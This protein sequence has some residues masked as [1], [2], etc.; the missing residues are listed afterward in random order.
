MRM[1]PPLSPFI[2]LFAYS[3]VC[4]QGAHIDDLFNSNRQSRLDSYSKVSRHARR[5]VGDQ[6]LG[7][8]ERSNTLWQEY[9]ASPSAQFHVEELIFT[10]CHYRL[11]YAYDYTVQFDVD[12]FW[13]PGR[14]S[15]AKT[16]PD[17]L[18]QHM[19]KD[20]ASIGFKQVSSGNIVT[21]YLASIN[22]TLRWQQSTRA[23][24]CSSRTMRYGISKLWMAYTSWLM[25]RISQ[26]IW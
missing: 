18:D 22:F 3:S 25:A 26:R 16:L 6:P 2:Q 13:M 24:Y 1:L 11:R 17:F 10:A 8:F 5:H 12:E 21:H 7:R 9:S 4:C 23:G 15:E 19:N 14:N 20:A